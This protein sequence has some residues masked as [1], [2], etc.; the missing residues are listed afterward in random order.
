MLKHKV[1]IEY[2]F[3]LLLCH[4]SSLSKGSTQL[5][6][7]AYFQFSCFTKKK[8]KNQIESALEMQ[9]IQLELQL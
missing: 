6:W 5:N 4:N 2:I 9:H 1:L 3:N 7:V 8:K